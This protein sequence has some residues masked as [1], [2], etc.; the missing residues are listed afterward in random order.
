MPNR[1]EIKSELDVNG[2]DTTKTKAK[3]NIR[4]DLSAERIN[5]FKETIEIKATLYNDNV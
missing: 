5:T 3:E 4:F 2:S 1:Q